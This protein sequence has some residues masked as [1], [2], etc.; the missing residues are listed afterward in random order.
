MIG[1]LCPLLF[2]VH[3]RVP[4][5]RDGF[6]ACR[7]GSELSRDRFRFQVRASVARTSIRFDEVVD[8]PREVARWQ[9]EG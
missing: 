2:Q 6:S 9:G 3:G 7:I 1:W 5:T 8:E 4:E